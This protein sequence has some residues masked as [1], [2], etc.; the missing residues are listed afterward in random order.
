MDTSS[1]STHTSSR[2]GLTVGYPPGWTVEPATRNWTQ[3][4]DVAVMDSPGSERFSSAEGDVYVTVFAVPFHPDKE[5]VTDVRAWIQDYCEDAIETCTGIDDRAVDLCVEKRDCH[6]GLLVPYATN[7]DAYFTGGHYNSQLV[8]VSVR[9]N[10][11]N[12]TV[13]GRYGSFQRLLEGFLSTMDVWPAATIE[14][15]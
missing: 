14:F 10:D 6:P 5:T 15:P 2:Y 7:V 3:E 8:V 9:R 1:W 4:T 13:Q 12:I 11:S